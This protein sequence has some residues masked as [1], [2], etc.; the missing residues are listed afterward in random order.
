[1][2]L[3]TGCSVLGGGG[4]SLN[5][6]CD[7]TLP[8]LD[9]L[10]AVSAGILAGI[11]IDEGEGPGTEATVVAGIFAA[12]AYYGYDKARSCRA[13][14]KDAAPAQV[15]SVRDE[16]LGSQKWSTTMWVYPKESPLLALERAYQRAAVICEGRGLSALDA[17][18]LEPLRPRQ[19]TLTFKC[20]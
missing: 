9:S 19:V 13:R 7:R 8:A 12:S 5:K 18:R 4:R 14:T 10:V 20:H 3:A 11:T 2:V 1:M 17:T 15:A 16:F 6:T